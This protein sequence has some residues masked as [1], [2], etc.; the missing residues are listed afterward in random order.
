MRRSGTFVALLG[1]AL[2][3]PVSSSGGI[4]PSA[5]PAAAASTIAGDA[6][7]SGAVD[8]I[9]S[10]VILRG[11]AGLATPPCTDLADVQCDGDVDPVDSL[12]ILRFDAGLSVIQQPGCTSIGEQMA[13]SDQLIEQALANGDITD[14][15]AIIYRVFAAFSDSRLPDEYDGAPSDLPDSDAAMVAAVK[16]AGLSPQAQAILRPFLTPPYAPGSW[17]H[18]ATVGSAHAAATTETPEPTIDPAEWTTFWAADG[19]VKVWARNI[20]PGELAKAPLVAAAITDTIWPSLI[21]LMG[22]EHAPLSDAGY[23]NDGG[24]GALDVYLVT[25]EEEGTLG[26]AIPYIDMPIDPKTWQVGPCELSPAYIQVDGSE[27]LGSAGAPGILSTTAHEIFH[28]FQLSFDL[29]T[30]CYY[31]EY[32]WFMEAS[33][34]WAMDYVYPLANAEHGAAGEFFAAPYAPLDAVLPIS[35]HEYGAY[36]FPFYLARSFHDPGV[37]SRIWGSFATNPSIAGIQS[38]IEPLGGFGALWAEFILGNFNWD[39]TTVH[40]YLDWDGL[41]NGV[42]LGNQTSSD[43]MSLYAGQTKSIPADVDYLAAKYQRVIFFPGTEENRLRSAVFRNTLVDYA[44]ASV[45][46]FIKTANGWEAE[47]WTAKTTR[48]FCLDSEDGWV[49][50]VVV[51]IGNSDWEGAN[52]LA[53]ATQPS[54]VGSEVPCAWQGEAHGTH[55]FV[56]AEQD[57]AV[58]MD[59]TELVFFPSVDVEGRFEALSGTVT[60]TFSGVA[61]YDEDNTPGPCLM[62]GTKSVPVDAGVSWHYIQIIS[63]AGGTLHYRGS[64]LTVFDVPLVISCPGDE[65]MPATNGSLH[66][67]STADDEA[68]TNPKVLDGSW[69]TTT[70]FMGTHITGTYHWHFTAAEA[71]AAPATRAR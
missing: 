69:T 37:V 10:L 46:A 24:D 63:E 44:H 32:K 39:Q 56:G 16:F 5:S 25:I 6:N 47:D 36:L 58:Q 45:Q 18:L 50:E 22:Q 7:C 67:L 2:L 65:P 28:A 8:P 35:A 43:W 41:A 62:T 33:S 71:S 26:E 68:T 11:D 60:A 38:V 34:T 3:L 1:L 55:T 9:D 17:L 21:A 27:P 61:F 59:A 70:D 40:P 48:A 23:P 51:I 19:E 13:S 42:W 57:W 30:N 52:D 49:D 15:E 12:Q 53:P 66:W 20:Y 54:F 31:P 14:E 4:P 29:Y 64:G